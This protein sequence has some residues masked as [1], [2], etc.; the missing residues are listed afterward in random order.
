MKLLHQNGLRPKR[1]KG[2]LEKNESVSA[3]KNMM[4]DG[5]RGIDYLMFKHG[6]PELVFE[7]DDTVK[8]MIDAGLKD[9]EINVGE[10]D[11]SDNFE[12]TLST[13]EFM[14][15][16]SFVI[17]TTFDEKIESFF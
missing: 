15:C 13:E 14:K 4:Q 1:K 5:M 9:D 7:T 6:I 2:S 10:M 8:R 16:T 11:L 3:F 17:A 12:P